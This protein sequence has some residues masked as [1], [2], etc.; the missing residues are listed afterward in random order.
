MSKLF[1]IHGDL[2]FDGFEAIGGYS[3]R[4]FGPIPPKSIRGS[5]VI[6][7]D[8]SISGYCEGLRTKPKLNWDKKYYLIGYIKK[9]NEDNGKIVLFQLAADGFTLPLQFSV[10]NMDTSTTSTS[11]Y[12]YQLDPEWGVFA[13]RNKAKFEFREEWSVA[14][15]L[16]IDQIH[17][18]FGQCEDI[19]RGSFYDNEL[20]ICYQQYLSRN[21]RYEKVF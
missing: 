16:S 11:G 8:G 10:D 12:W 20:F 7:N 1:S 17:S 19:I 6:E 21:S 5:I 13:L 9:N 14:Y 15:G 2:Y 18:M 3:D 4:Y